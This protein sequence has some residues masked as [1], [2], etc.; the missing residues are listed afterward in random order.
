[1]KYFLVFLC[2][3]LMSEGGPEAFLFFILALGLL[4]V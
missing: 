2:M 4:V 3:L 1:M